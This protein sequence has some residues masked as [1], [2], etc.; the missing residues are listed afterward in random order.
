ML[1]IFNFLCVSLLPSRCQW[2][3]LNIC[4]ICKRYRI[5]KS[6]I[7][8][9]F[10]RVSRTHLIIIRIK[11][12]LTLTKVTTDISP[13]EK[14]NAREVCM[15]WNLFDLVKRF[16]KHV[17][18]WF[19]RLSC[20]SNRQHKTYLFFFFGSFTPRFV[21]LTLFEITVKCCKI[22]QKILN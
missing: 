3:C 18:S 8:R 17:W 4:W 16:E 1:L 12:Q 13:T 21:S 5:K 19:Y 6:S 7:F 10:N 14:L 9:F 2:G 11:I 20:I 15:R 22:L